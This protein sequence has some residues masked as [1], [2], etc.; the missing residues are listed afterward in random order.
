MNTNAVREAVAAGAQVVIDNLKRMAPADHHS[1]RSTPAGS[2]IADMEKLI[3]ARPNSLK[4]IDAVWSAM[5][6][7]SEYSESGLEDYATR[8]ALILAVAGVL[9]GQP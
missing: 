8:R 4:A 3:A 5:L 7:T 9:G 6:T 2:T 1:D